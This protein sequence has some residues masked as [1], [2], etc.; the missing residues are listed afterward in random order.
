MTTH[1][2]VASIASEC[3]LIVC[4]GALTPDRVSAIFARV[5]DR[6]DARRRWM[7]DV[8]HAHTLFAVEAEDERINRSTT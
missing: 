8:E 2:D 7:E 1:P 5:D 6:L 3:A 4:L